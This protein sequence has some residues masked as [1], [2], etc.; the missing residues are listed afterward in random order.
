M[1]K[2]EGQK[3]FYTH[4]MAVLKGLTQVQES[5]AKDNGKVFDVIS[6]R[7]PAC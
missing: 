1:A 4:G 3:V 6:F 7:V 2:Q 5:S